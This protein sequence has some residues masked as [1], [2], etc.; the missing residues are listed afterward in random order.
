MHSDSISSYPSGEFFVAQNE[1]KALRSM[2]VAVDFINFSNPFISNNLFVRR[3][4]SLFSS[5]WS[6]YSSYR[7]KALYKKFSPDIIH[8]HGVFPY[9]SSSAIFAAHSTKALVV[10]TLHNGR[11]LC[12]E[13]G[14][15]RNGQY[16]DACVTEGGF[17]G[18]VHGCKHGQIPSF[19]CY[20]GAATARLG[21]RLFNWVDCFIAVSEFIRD[22]HIRAGFPPDQIIVK[23]NSVDLKKLSSI[24]PSSPPSGFIFFGRISQAKGFEILK[25]LISHF[26][27][28]PIRIVGD[29]PFLQSLKD[30]CDSNKYNH[31]TIWGK[32]SQEKCF[33]LIASS[34]FTVL[35]SQCGEA[36]PL[37][38]LESLGLGVPVVGSDIGGLGP[39]IKKSQGGL[40]VNPSDPT[41]FINSVSYLLNN[42]SQAERMGRLG[43]Q[44]VSHFLNS[45]KLTRDLLVTYHCLLQSREQK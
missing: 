7:I 6:F 31:V 19:F 34:I 30:F 26:T 43:C 11:W 15:Y 27:A 16:C 38:A 18:V 42:P 25:V 29:G 28:Y 12:L 40:S 45:N 21:N 9:L 44:Y 23:N 1:F 22:Q 5:V 24:K 4:Q 14:F 2:G 41:S 37:S 35:P 10:Q 20:A 33:E 8:F 32:Q 36:F 39:F 3:V 13:G 17:T